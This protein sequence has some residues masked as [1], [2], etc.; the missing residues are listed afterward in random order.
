M[1]HSGYEEFPRAE[2]VAFM[3]RPLS[4]CG[5]GL[6]TLPWQAHAYIDPGTGSYFLQVLVAG[7]L[8]ASFAVEHFWKNLTAFFRNLGSKKR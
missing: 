4:W 6:L 3:L 7:I 8:G 2:I 1:L 5:L